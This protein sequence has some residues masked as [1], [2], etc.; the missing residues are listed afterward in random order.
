VGRGE[1]RGGETVQQYIDIWISGLEPINAIEAV[2]TDAH[3]ADRAQFR[4]VNRF[5]DVN[6]EDRYGDPDL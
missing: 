5:F 1:F 4:G 2:I 6:R 3:L